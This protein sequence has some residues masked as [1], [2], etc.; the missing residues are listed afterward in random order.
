MTERKKIMEKTHREHG[1]RCYNVAFGHEFTVAVRLLL[2]LLRPGSHS[3]FRRRKNA[4]KHYCRR[5]TARGREK[6]GGTTPNLPWQ[7]EISHKKEKKIQGK[8][9]KREVE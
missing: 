3:N 1:A 4:T 9:V 2:L 6:E 7:V 8:L 5:A